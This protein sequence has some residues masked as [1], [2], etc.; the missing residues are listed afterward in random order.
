M[1]INFYA[2]IA[3]PLDVAGIEFQ[4]ILID[5][6]VGDR[7]IEACA[8]LDGC[9]PSD[10][11]M[12]GMIYSVPGTVVLERITS[13]ADE[14]PADVVESCLRHITPHQASFWQ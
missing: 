14:L 2:D 13:F 5:R 7:L 10:E 4:I 11:C 8:D 9:Y 1:S 6:A 12:V 3:G